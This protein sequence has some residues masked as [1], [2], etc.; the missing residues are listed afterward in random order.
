MVEV[1]VKRW[2]GGGRETNGQRIHVGIHMIFE[3]SRMYVEIHTV[4]V[5]GEAL[6]DYPKLKLFNRF[7]PAGGQ[8]YHSS[9]P[10]PKTS[11]AEEQLQPNITPSLFCRGGYLV[12]VN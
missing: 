7:E 12:V 9:P 4:R 8:S 1:L 5:H 6:L 2:V 11:P 3:I 10:L